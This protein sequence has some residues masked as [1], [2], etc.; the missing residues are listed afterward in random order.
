[1][2][3]TFEREISGFIREIS[4]PKEYNRLG[5]TGFVLNNATQQEGLPPMRLTIHYRKLR[6]LPPPSHISIL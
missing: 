6:N 1:M 3:Q 2:C 4:S 5:D